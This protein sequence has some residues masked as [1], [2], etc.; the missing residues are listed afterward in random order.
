[1]APHSAISHHR[2]ADRVQR[3]LSTVVPEHWLVFQWLGMAVPARLGLYVPDL[4]V[5]PEMPTEGHDD[6]LPAAAAQLVV[7]ITSAA[8]ARYDRTTK[9]AGYAEAGGAALS[10]GRRLGAGRPDGHP[11]RGAEE[12]RV[13]P[14]ARRQ[15]RRTHHAAGT[16]RPR[17]RHR[18]VPGQ[19]GHPNNAA[20]TTSTGTASTVDSRIASLASTSPTR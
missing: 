15:V 5:V 3:S 4:A 6:F 16:L 1:M 18:R 2:I 17:T 12:R 19:P 8:T 11:V 9:A 13:P 14:P 7:E 10:P 20:T